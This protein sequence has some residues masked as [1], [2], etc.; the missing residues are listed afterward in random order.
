M[1]VCV[2]AHA[3]ESGESASAE[4]ERGGDVWELRNII[5]IYVTFGERIV[6][7]TMTK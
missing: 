5:N 1:C 6:I 2:Y 3:R 4:R 7:E